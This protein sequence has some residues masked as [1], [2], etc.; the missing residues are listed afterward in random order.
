MLCDYTITY[1]G[2]IAISD[3]G[4]Y[5]FALALLT[6]LTYH[7]LSNVRTMNR[8]TKDPSCY[9]NY[10]GTSTHASNANLWSVLTAEEDEGGLNLF[11][12]CKTAQLVAT[13]IQDVAIVCLTLASLVQLAQLAF[14]MRS[15]RRDIVRG[16]HYGF[17]F[18]H[19]SDCGCEHNAPYHAHSI[20][21]CV[22]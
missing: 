15:Y 18:V 22:M 3:V 9:Y 12:R 17:S 21:V 20:S 2:P 16:N 10:V 13:I 19:N 11:K 7:N 8:Y 4:Q 14:I 1:L 6:A 5:D